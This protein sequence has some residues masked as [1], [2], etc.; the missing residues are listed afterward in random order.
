MESRSFD[1][2]GTDSVLEP[3]YGVQTLV[4]YRNDFKV[5]KFDDG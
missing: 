5:I 3:Y 1:V 2:L 4:R